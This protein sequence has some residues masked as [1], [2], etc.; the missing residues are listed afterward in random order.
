MELIGEYFEVPIERGNKILLT[1]RFGSWT[2]VSKD[3]LQKIKSTPPEKLPKNLRRKLETACIL[4]NQSTYQNIIE[5]IKKR[6]VYHDFP[7]ITIQINLTYRCNLACKYC[8]ASSNLGCVKDADSEL[9]NQIIKFVKSLPHEYI[10][11]EFQGG[12]PFLRF[13]LIQEFYEKLSKET[14]GNKK[15]VSNV[16]V[17][18]I[19]LLDGDIIKA[20]KQ[21]NISLCSSLDGPREIHDSQRI[22]INGRGSYDAVISSLKLAEENNLH[23]SLITTVT[24]NTLKYG[25]AKAILEEYMRLNRKSIYYNPVK[26]EGMAKQNPELFL[27]GEEYFHFVRSMVDQITELF[28]KKIY[29]RDKA[30]GLY[31]RNI[32]SPYRTFACMRDVCGAGTTHL[33]VSP[34]GDIFPCDIMKRMEDMKLGNIFEDP[35]SSIVLRSMELR[36]AVIDLNP[37]CDMCPWVGFCGFC[38]GDNYSEHGTLL[39]Y[40]FADV[41]CEFKRMLFRYIFENIDGFKKYYDL[42]FR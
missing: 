29:F 33:V 24:R 25:G 16:I 37:L 7:F 21:H 28:K 12:E 23:V 34:E 36:S 2:F 15:I 26:Y 11:F 32:F 18:N 5:N 8:H 6:F 35:Y 42:L 19:T 10:S 20:L 41:D 9:I 30:L 27:S 1:T 31:L 3:E 40:K 39:T 14:L 17:S 4:I 38:K 22:F 13:D